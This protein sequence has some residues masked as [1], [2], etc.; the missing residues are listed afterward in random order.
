MPGSDKRLLR[1]EG[2]RILVAGDVGAAES[3]FRRL[4]GQALRPQIDEHQMGVGTAGHEAVPSGGDRLPERLGV[5]HHILRVS[6]EG[7]P[8][9][10][11]ESD[12]LGGDDVHQRTALKAGEHRRIDLL[13]DLLVIGEDH[14]AARAAQGLVG[15]GGHH[16]RVGERAWDA[17]RPRPARRNGPCRP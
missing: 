1:I 4:A 3:G 13:G 2:H 6:P 7:G 15:R 11:A 12:R 5:G 14:A 17:R 16:M 10:L 9:R 8:Q